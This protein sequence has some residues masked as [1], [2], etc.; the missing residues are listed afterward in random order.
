MR[1][2]RR[3]PE[4][5]LQTTQTQKCHHGRTV[6]TDLIMVIFLS[7]WVRIP[8]VPISVFSGGGGGL[9]QNRGWDEIEQSSLFLRQNVLFQTNSPIYDDNF[10]FE[11]I[12]SF[13]LV[14]PI[15]LVSQ[16]GFLS[17]FRKLGLLTLFFIKLGVYP[18]PCG[19]IGHIPY[20][21]GISEG[22]L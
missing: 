9:E 4:Q 16:N 18:S 17:F 19:V 20:L 11:V 22:N 8:R 14:N 5:S 7:A 13:C 21:K 2:Y 6:D 3:K 10:E 1:I 15:I 12:F